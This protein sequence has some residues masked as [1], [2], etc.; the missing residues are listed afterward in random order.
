MCVSIDRQRGV[1]TPRVGDFRLHRMRLVLLIVAAV[2]LC[3]LPTAHAKPRPIN[4]ILNDATLVAKDLS[5]QVAKYIPEWEEDGRFKFKEGDEHYDVMKIVM[6]FLLE[7]R[8]DLMRMAAES[9]EKYKKNQKFT[10]TQSRIDAAIS[11][12]CKKNALAGSV[13]TF[14]PGSPAVLGG[15]ASSL[16]LQYYLVNIIASLRGYDISSDRVQSLV[17]L[18]FLADLGTEGIHRSTKK[19]SS[20]ALSQLVQMAVRRISQNAVQKAVKKWALSFVPLVGSAIGGAT[21]YYSCSWTAEHAQS[22]IFG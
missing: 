15:V 17:W 9:A 3:I 18:T 2:L 7:R 11:Y 21:D 16:A 19:L 6:D 8:D 20:A 1:H 14:I 12:E 10:T 22:E 13:A 4:D 5:A